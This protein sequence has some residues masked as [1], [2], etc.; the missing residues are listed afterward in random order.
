MERF[1]NKVDKTET[2]WN[3]TRFC[4]KGRGRFHFNGKPEYAPRV[5]WFLTH[6]VWPE[7]YVLH[8]CDNP[9]CVNPE[10]L[11]LGTHLENLQDMFVKDRQAKG[12]SHGVSKLTEEDILEIRNSSKKQKDL[13]I[14]FGVSKGTISMVVNNLIWRHI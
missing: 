7:E 1:W 14:D 3:W 11:F 5:S 9:A 8:T 12:E 6:G 4:L 13:A 10:H 2:C